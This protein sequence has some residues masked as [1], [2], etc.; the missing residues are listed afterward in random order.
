MCIGMATSTQAV[1]KVI[2]IIV[3]KAQGLAG[4]WYADC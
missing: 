4:M 1:T 3:V 2:G